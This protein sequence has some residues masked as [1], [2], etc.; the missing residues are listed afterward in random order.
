LKLKK[1]IH[2]SDVYGTLLEVEGVRAVRQLYLQTCKNNTVTPLKGWKYRIP[3]NHI[4][5]FSLACSGFQL[6]RN[7]MPVFIDF[8]KFEG[9]FAINFTHNGKI[10]YD[11]PSPYLNA[12]IPKGIHRGD[13]GDYYSIQNEFPRVYGIAEGGLSESATPQR[14]AQAYQLKS[15]LLFFDQ[16]FANYL[17]Q[18]QHIRSLFALS[19]TENQKEN[20]TYFIRQ[21]TTVPDLQKLLRFNVN[22]NNSN[23]LG[24]EGSLL[25]FPVDKKKLLKLKEQ[26]QLKTLSLEDVK[27]YTFA[28]LADQ[29]IVINLV[30]D[31]LYF[32]QYECEYIT[33]VDDCVFY[34]ILTSSDEIA[35]ISK[36][37]FKNIRE[38][39]E[40]ATSVKYIGTFDENYRSLI[41]KDNVF[42]FTIELNLL[43][44]SKYL[45]L[46]VEDK[47]LFGQ[48]RHGFLN[49]LLSRFAEQFTDYALLSFGFY[50]K[51]QAEAASIRSKER[52]LTNYDDLSSNRGKAYDYLENNWN[53]NN[54]SGFE[55][56]FKAISGIDNWK[57][58]S[59]CNFVVAEY[60]PQYAVTLK[61]AGT[62]Y[63]STEEKF[64][65]KEEALVAAHFL[66]KALA[67]KSNYTSYEVPYDKSFRLKI[68][69][70]EDR[71]AEYP[72]RFSSGEDS[73]AVATNIT[74]L[75][76]EQPP[77]ESVFESAYMYVPLLKDAAGKSIR[78][79]IHLYTTD[80]EA[81]SGALKAVK[82][83]D[84]RKL[85]AY[86]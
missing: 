6:S 10:L 27:P 48:R 34:Y 45:Q 72:S 52:F 47:E 58:H 67:D 21:L 36:R 75:F 57:R 61:I 78:K 3:E 59:L 81:T 84:D 69:Y 23:P 51:Q 12:E 64:E 85:W 22:E 26:D 31:D 30:K 17:A 66:F 53:N 8:S 38:A 86:E 71:W 19:E 41:T 28:T 20:H 32:E 60:D 54:V 29:D 70:A 73:V 63:F 77:G 18:L 7:D 15:Y 9:V 40:N 13:L 39:T 46:I 44:F 35:L 82:K 80:K 56:K 25:A 83:I 68:K 33:K 24:T 74:N 55:K 65:S 37:Y 42:S 76:K 1:E 79:S 5:E 4:A 14:K 49:H 50:N 16:L 43:S 2:L 62:E 11:S